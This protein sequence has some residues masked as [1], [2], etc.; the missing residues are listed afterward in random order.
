MKRKYYTGENEKSAVTLSQRQIC[1]QI[2]K[3]G[4]PQNVYVDNPACQRIKN[5]TDEQILQTALKT[6][7]WEN[8][9]RLRGLLYSRILCICQNK[10]LSSYQKK[11]AIKVLE[12]LSDTKMYFRVFFELRHELTL[13]IRM[14]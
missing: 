8:S 11:K 14:V 12:H 1:R 5:P 13:L 2:E 6:D 7:T 10:K 4:I 9:S 3:H